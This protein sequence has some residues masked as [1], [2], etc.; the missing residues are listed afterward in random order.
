MSKPTLLDAKID[1]AATVLD[2]AH[3]GNIIVNL[4][5]F[6]RDSNGEDRSHLKIDL[7]RYEEYQAEGLALKDKIEDYI[8]NL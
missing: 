2:L 8:A 1:L 7:M 6:M 3:L 5:A 4:R